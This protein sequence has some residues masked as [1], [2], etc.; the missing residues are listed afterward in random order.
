V[1]QVYE[2]LVFMDFNKALME[3]QG[4][5]DYEYLP[6]DL[7]PPL[8][9]AYRAELSEGTEVFHN[10]IRDRWNRGEPEVVQAMQHWAGLT[11]QVR[12]LLLA[13]RGREIGPLLNE[14]F[15]Q[16][17]RIYQIGEGNLRM[18][19]TARACGASAAFTGSG[20]AITGICPDEAT[21]ARLQQALERIGCPV[22]RPQFVKPAPE[23]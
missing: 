10:N 19:E 11:D 7:L 6:L 20:G 23:A 16:R 9:I 2:G 17:R 4:H 18:I 1:A 15:D 13:G 5:G 22:L 14:G 3:R 12:A 21:F 8:Y